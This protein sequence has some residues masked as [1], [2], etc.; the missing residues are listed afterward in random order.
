MIFQIIVKKTKR[1]LDDYILYSIPVIT[2]LNK[3]VRFGYK[4]R[5]YYYLLKHFTFTENSSV[6]CILRFWNDSKNIQHSCVNDKDTYS[7]SKFKRR[8]S[9]VW[10]FQFA[11]I[12]VPPMI[13]SSALMSIGLFRASGVGSHGTVV[14]QGMV[15]FVSWIFLMALSLRSIKALVILTMAWNKTSIGEFVF[16]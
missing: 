11:A 7:I 8:D 16:E 6:K 4:I 1:N 3:K 5:D 14:I 15:I 2:V 9:A 13:I 12:I 10:T